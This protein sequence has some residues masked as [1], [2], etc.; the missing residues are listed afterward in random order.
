MVFSAT[1]K[2]VKDSGRC[3]KRT[4]QYRNANLKR[5]LAYT[6]GESTKALSVQTGMLVKSFGQ[7]QRE[8][9]LREGKLQSVSIPAKTMVAMKSDLCVPWE[10]LKTMGR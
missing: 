10:K 4:L 2:A 8:Q 1:T 7:E 9:I 5:Q 3:C 6:A